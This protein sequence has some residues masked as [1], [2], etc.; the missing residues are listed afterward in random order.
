[1]GVYNK[2]IILEF[3]GV[4]GCGKTTTANLLKNEL[5]KI[6]YKVGELNELFHC[7]KIVKNLKICISIIH[8]N[9]VFFLM[10]LIK[11]VF[12]V[13]PMNLSRLKYIKIAYY[14]YYMINYSKAKQ[15]NYDFLILDQG[16]I[17]SLISI[18]HSDNIY[19]K[20]YLDKILM[21]I[22]Y[23]L[24]NICYIN[25]D[26]NNEESVLRI[27]ARGLSQGRLDNIKDFDQLI[28]TLNKQNE[29]LRGIRREL[30]ELEPT[31]L[32][33]DLDMKEKSDINLQKILKKITTIRN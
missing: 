17:Q 6:G 8:M 29:N 10:N 19:N 13:K 26:I 2:T 5:S 7:N 32:K 25:C 20:K 21:N 30:L 4:P 15:N 12:S 14:N 23:K 1:M 11:F 27:K 9:N 3:N 22:T 24:D 18:S 28:D 31:H 33:V 16:L